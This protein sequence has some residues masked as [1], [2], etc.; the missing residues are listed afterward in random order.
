M[1]SARNRTSPYYLKA[2]TIFRTSIAY[3]QAEGFTGE[4]LRRRADSHARA[5][6]PFG[7]KKHW[8]YKQWRAARRDI[9]FPEKGSLAAAARLGKKAKALGFQKQFRQAQR[10][11]MPFP[12]PALAAPQD[13]ECTGQ[14]E[15]KFQ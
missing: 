10:A 11:R 5:A 3:A 7:V 4:E 12:P 9:L 2:A 1:A 13:I 6:Y 14:E 8:P 15:F